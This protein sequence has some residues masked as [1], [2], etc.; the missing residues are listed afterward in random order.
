VEENE[1][2]IDGKWWSRVRRT[3][4]ILL[5]GGRMSG[6]LYG[7]YMYL[8]MYHRDNGKINEHLSYR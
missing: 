6:V 7:L 5:C 4:G 8:L 3:K 2:E 1:D